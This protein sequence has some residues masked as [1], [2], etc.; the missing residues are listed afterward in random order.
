MN[1]DDGRERLLGR[2]PYI[3]YTYL[4]TL[5]TYLP[6]QIQGRLGGSPERNGETGKRVW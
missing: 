4:P 3:I 6:R 5:G 2:G 1:V